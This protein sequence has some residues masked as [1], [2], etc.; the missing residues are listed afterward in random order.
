M[1]H[2]IRGAALLATVL[3]VLSCA[4]MQTPVEVRTTDQGEKSITITASSFK[5]E[6]SH[7][8][9]RQGD[10]LNINI[11][12]VSSTDHNFSMKDPRGNIM[13]SEDVPAKGMVEVKVTLKEPGT[14]EFFCHRPLHPTLGMKGLLEVRPSP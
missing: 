14:Y 2:Y 12:N 11:E 4:R 5:F 3:A 9:T 13:M 7:I 8:V 1:V 6:P 10:A